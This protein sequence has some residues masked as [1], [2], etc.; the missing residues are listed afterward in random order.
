MIFLA[1]LAPKKNVACI[2]ALKVCTVLT[3]SQ[4]GVDISVI[5]T[6]QKM[7]PFWILIFAFLDPNSP[8]EGQKLIKN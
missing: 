6:K 8:F 4:F 7:G 1:L 2:W 5:I 3:L